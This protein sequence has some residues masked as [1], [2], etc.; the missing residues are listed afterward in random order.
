MNTLG[1]TQEDLNASSY[2]SSIATN[3][4]I[5]HM[6]QSTYFNNILVFVSREEE[7]KDEAGATGRGKIKDC[8]SPAFV[9]P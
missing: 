4:H 3:P 6:P 5:P 1:T 9:S 2:K 7:E 8:N